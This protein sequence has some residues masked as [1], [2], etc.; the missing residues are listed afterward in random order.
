MQVTDQAIVLDRRQLRDI[1]MDDEELMHEVL[2]SLL[3]DTSKQIALM[4]HAIRHRDEQKTMRLAHY[5]K[6]ACANLGANATAAVL[7]R[8]E[9]EASRHCFEDCAASLG[10]LRQ[11]LERLR[12][13]AAAF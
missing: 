1:T 7:R 12:Q 8:L 5:C 11:E 6:G 10:N 3:A 2:S 13:E 9:Q 4:D